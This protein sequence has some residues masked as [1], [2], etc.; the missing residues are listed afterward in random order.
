MPSKPRTTP[1]RS[2]L[3]Y[4]IRIVPLHSPAARATPAVPPKLTYRNGPLLTSVQV[5]TIFWGA[6]WNQAPQNT[7]IQ[8]LN[9]FFD[10]VLASPLLDQLDEYSVPGKKIGHGALIGTVTFT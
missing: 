10:F 2:E 7:L 9:E 5:F 8:E 4:P 1:K 6:A 3:F